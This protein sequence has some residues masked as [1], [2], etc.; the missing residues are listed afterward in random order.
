MTLDLSEA[1]GRLKSSRAHRRSDVGTQRTR[2]AANRMGPGPHARPRCDPRV[3]ETKE[4]PSWAEDRDGAPR[5]GEDRGPRPLA[6][7][8]RREGPARIVQSSLHGRQRRL[9]SFGGLRPRGICEKVGDRGAV[10]REPPQGPRPET[11]PR[12]RRW[13]GPRLPVAHE[14]DR[15]ALGRARGKRGDDDGHH[16]PPGDGAGWRA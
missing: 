1:T 9:G 8:G 12:D 4:N 16:P 11:G 14:T 7:R 6:P 10:L 5:R 15:T 13:R 3:A 2:G